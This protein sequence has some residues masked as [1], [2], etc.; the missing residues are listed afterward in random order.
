MLLELK[1]I[2]KS[3]TL[4]EEVFHVLSGVNLDIE[5]W[6]FVAIMWP[7]GSGKSTLMNII[8]MLDT[9]TSWEFYINGK[10]VDTLSDSKQSRVRRESIGFIFQNY[11]LIP[12]LSVIEQVKLPLIYQWVSQKEATLLAQQSLEKVWL[13]GK[14]KSM[15]NE[16]S[17]GQKQRVAIA[18][19]IVIS[20]K[21]MLA[22]EPTGALDTKTSEEIMKIFHSLHQEGK[23]ILIITHEPEIAQQTKRII[24]IRDGNI[25][26]GI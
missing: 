14:E 9:P 19:A 10:R 3:Y 22:D 5:E 1:N 12:R 4:W 25:V 21:I 11:S 17:W 20:P 6:E 18:R 26:D 13:A 8:W 16:L 7:S 23:T 15:P 24:S 2:T